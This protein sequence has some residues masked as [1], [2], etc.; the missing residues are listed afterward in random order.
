MWSRD[1]ALQLGPVVP[2]LPISSLTLAPAFQGLLHLFSGSRP[3]QIALTDYK[4]E[5]KLVQG[6]ATRRYIL[7]PPASTFFVIVTS[8]RELSIHREAWFLGLNL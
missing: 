1:C 4:K 6:Q 7:K 8:C 2:K 3:S 5:S